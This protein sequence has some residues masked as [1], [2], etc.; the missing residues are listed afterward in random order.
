MDGANYYMHFK[1]IYSIKNVKRSLNMSGCLIL[2]CNV[3]GFGKYLLN[4]FL[5]GFLNINFLSISITLS[6]FC[7]RLSPYDSRVILYVTL[8]LQR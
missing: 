2:Y 3:N 1:Q 7:Y 4:R 6:L 8:R 5:K